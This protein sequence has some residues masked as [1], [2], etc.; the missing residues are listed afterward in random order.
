MVVLLL[1][2]WCMAVPTSFVVLLVFK[3]LCGVANADDIF[4][5]LLQIELC[6]AKSGI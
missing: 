3:S 2:C 6:K 4:A 1:A 5:H